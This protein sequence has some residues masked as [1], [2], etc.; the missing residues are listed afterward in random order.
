MLGIGYQVLAGLMHKLV[1]VGELDIVGD[2]NSAVIYP[3]TVEKF[4]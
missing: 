1:R 3:F 4:T 2:L